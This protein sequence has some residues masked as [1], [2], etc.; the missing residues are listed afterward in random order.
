MEVMA[1]ASHHTLLKRPD[2]MVTTPGMHC[3]AGGH[4]EAGR[5]VAVS[6]G[7]RVGSLK[8][9]LRGT[10]AAGARH[11]EA[12]RPACPPARSNKTRKTKTKPQKTPNKRKSSYLTGANT[13]RKAVKM[14]MA[15]A[16]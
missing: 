11:D 1:K 14:P 16:E 12:Q 3:T 15:A 2:R 4:R 13:W 7:R 8:G 6:A 5:C 9:L 10:G